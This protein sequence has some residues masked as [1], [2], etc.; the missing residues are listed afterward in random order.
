MN[1]SWEGVS[2]IVVLLGSFGGFAAY[3]NRIVEN[4]SR[5][6]SNLSNNF[7]TKDTCSAHITA[8]KEDMGDIKTSI[9]DI[10]TSMVVLA[11]KKT[12]V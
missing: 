8:I 4:Q 7:Q 11:Q 2:A 9:R 12:E 5:F 3:L 6:F 10:Q 1:L